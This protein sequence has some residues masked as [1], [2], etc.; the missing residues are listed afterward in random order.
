MKVQPSDLPNPD[1]RL[2]IPPEMQVK[3]AVVK[4]L[5][6]IMK[7]MEDSDGTLLLDLL[8][9]ICERFATDDL[10]IQNVN[11]H[12]HTQVSMGCPRH[13]DGHF[14]PLSAF[15]LLEE[16]EAAFGTTLQSLE[17]VT[18]G[19]LIGPTQ[20]PVS[21]RITRQKVLGITTTLSNI[22]FEVKCRESVTSFKNLMQLRP[23]LTQPIEL[24]VL[25]SIGREGWEALAEALR[26]QPNVVRRVTVESTA[27]REGTNKGL[28]DIWDSLEPTGFVQV[29]YRVWWCG[30]RLV[31]D[32]VDKQN[33]EDAWVE[34]EEILDVANGWNVY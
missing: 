19:T 4:S 8:D 33:G 34:L 22:E 1:L 32:R 6:E 26:F 10:F 15:L 14:I 30:G 7:L 23:V 29:L 12:K 3:I 28:R 5:V 2:S 13:P 27:L 11:Q 24:E 9:V 16:V 25:G 21:S 17:S 31:E 20:L 18:G